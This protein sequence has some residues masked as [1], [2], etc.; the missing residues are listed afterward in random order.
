MKK[1]KWILIKLFG[2]RYFIY[3]DKEIIKTILMYG[4]RI[5]I[6]NE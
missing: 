5:Y 4:H 1:I 3:K 2:K 6:L